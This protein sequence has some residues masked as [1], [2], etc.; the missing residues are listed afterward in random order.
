M[1][2]MVYNHSIKEVIYSVYNFLA[3]HTQKQ[4]KI[5][6]LLWMTLWCLRRIQGN[7][8]WIFT[9]CHG[10]W[11]WCLSNLCSTSVTLSTPLWMQKCSSIVE[12]FYLPLKICIRKRDNDDGYVKRIVGCPL[13]DFL[14]FRWTVFLPLQL[15][16]DFNALRSDYSSSSLH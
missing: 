12:D 16:A 6:V 3:F 10:N 4:L 9:F 2:L 14:K 8:V 1:S 11:D 15:V 7:W 13:M 5:S